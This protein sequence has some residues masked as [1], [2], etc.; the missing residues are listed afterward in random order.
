MS[1]LQ[2]RRWERYSKELDVTIAGPGGVTL[3]GR[4]QDVCEGGIGLLCVETLA[5]GSDY[6]FSIAEI[7]EAPLVGTVRWCTPSP[8]HGANVVGVE[9]TGLTSTQVHALTECIA[10]WKAQDAGSEDA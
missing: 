9:L 5:V 10:R 8:A 7:G 4:T 1:A 6:R 2:R 3:R